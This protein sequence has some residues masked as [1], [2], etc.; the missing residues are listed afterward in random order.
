MV[1]CDNNSS[2]AKRKAR[3]SLGDV[4]PPPANPAAPNITPP[5]TAEP[6]QN[7]AGVWH[8]TCG[9]GCAGGAGK[10][11]NCAT[12]GGTLAH[13]QAYHNN[14]TTPT[15]T[16]NITTTPTIPNATPP[17]QEPAQNAAGVWHY[18]CAN[19]CAGGGGKA[20][21]CSSCGGTLAHNQAYHQ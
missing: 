6:A 18:T 9:N 20:G 10:A 1:S 19:G 7:A 13:N 16:P 5:P 14:A 8:Y 3:E 17:T 12:C 11:G 2:E 21:P 4:T 15:T